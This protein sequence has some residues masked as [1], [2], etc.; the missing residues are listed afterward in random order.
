MDHAIHLRAGQEVEA[1]TRNSFAVDT[2]FVLFFLA[3]DFGHSAIFGGIE[4]FLPLATL[5]TFVAVPYFLPCDGERPAFGAWLLGRAFLVV[6]GVLAGL[7][8]RQA[9]GTVLPEY[10]SHLPM[11]FLIISAIFSCYFQFYGII[12]VRLAR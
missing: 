11:T 8:F 10:F 3:V 1:G 2:T 7:M 12:K 9:V 6:F 5:L 4:L